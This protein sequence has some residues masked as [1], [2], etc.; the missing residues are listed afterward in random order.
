MDVLS[1][2]VAKAEELHLI[3]PL[4]RRPL[5]H[6]LSL[7]AD[8]VV[9]FTSAK[10][11][12]INLIKAL[13]GKFGN[14][15]G[16]RAN[17]VKSSIVTIRCQEQDVELARPHMDCQIASFPCKYLSLPLSINKLTKTDLQPILDRIADA[18][19]GWKAA[20]M[21]TRRY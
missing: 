9:M 1:R 10:P 15:S 11:E 6:R 21:A 12:D 14:A 18:L 8:D 16:L 20:L 7:Y 2:L 13:L 19:P 4:A 17:M 5:P 3:E